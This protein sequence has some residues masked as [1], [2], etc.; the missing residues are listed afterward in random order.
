MRKWIVIRGETYVVQAVKRFLVLVFAIINHTNESVCGH[1]PRVSAEY[2][3]IKSSGELLRLR[4]IVRV[5]L[6]D[7]P[8]T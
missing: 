6:I 5:F 7:C 2:L 1:S 3:S 8:F 4:D